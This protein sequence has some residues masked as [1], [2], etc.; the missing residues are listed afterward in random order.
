MRVVSLDALRGAAA[1]VVVVFH[2]PWVYGIEIPK[3]Y[4]A[5][6]FF[7]VLSGWVMAQSYEKRIEAGLSFPS[8][9][10]NRLARLYPLYLAALLLGATAEGI[11][12]FGGGASGKLACVLPNLGMVPCIGVGDTAWPLNPPSWSIFAELLV[13]VGWFF[14]IRAGLTSRRAKL[15]LH[16]VFAIAMW[17]WIIW[18]GRFLEGFAPNN[19]PEG[20]VRASA[21]FAMGL[22]MHELRN[23]WRGVACCA[24]LGAVAAVALQVGLRE[25]NT[26]WV[27]AVLV[28]VFFP[29]VVWVA[30]HV[31]PWFL[32]GRFAAWMGDISFAVYL[33][34]IPLFTWTQRGLKAVLGEP[35]SHLLSGVLFTVALLLLS[36]LS[37][38]CF[39]VPA[40]KWIARRGW[41]WRASPSAADGAKP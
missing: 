36:T 30:A 5:V 24:A 34:H 18:A 11:K 26:L 33:L 32:E 14:A 40:R 8:F 29:A 28:L 4:L 22:L 38:Y 39:E 21:G 37:F 35:H 15:V 10:K 23:N 9:I 41:G 17:G 25:A 1:A 2:L 19:V 20:I 16:V 31:R 6:D 12:A 3:A 27:D 7:F 13:N